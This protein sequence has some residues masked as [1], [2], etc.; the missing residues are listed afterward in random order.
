M[1]IYS[2]ASILGGE[3]VIGA[4][5]VIGGNAFITTSIPA[6]TRVSIKNQE[7]RYEAGKAK[8]HSME[9]RQDDTWYY[10]I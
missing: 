9:L 10:M 2:G 7:L 6:G 8:L 3:T 4:G 1:T 5:A